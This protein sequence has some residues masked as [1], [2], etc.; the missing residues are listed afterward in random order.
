MRIDYSAKVGKF[1]VSGMSTELEDLRAIPNRKY[2]KTSG[3][4]IAGL[5]R[6]NVNYLRRW[7]HKATKEAVVMMKQV[8]Q[9][10]VIRKGALPVSFRFRTDPKPHQLEPLLRMMVSPSYALTMDPGTGKTKVAIDAAVCRFLERKINAELVV[11]PNSIKSNWEDEIGIHGAGEHEVFIYDPSMK[12]R[13]DKWC[14]TSFPGKL[15]WL[16][17]GV[18]SFSQGSAWKVAEQFLVMHHAGFDLDESSRIKTHDSTRTE[19]LI[20]L[21]RFAKFQTTMTGTPIS[22][23]LHQFWPQYEFLDPNILDMGFYAFRNHFSVM[24]GY[25]GKQIIGS[26][27]QEEFIDLVAPNTFRASKAECLKDLPPKIYQERKVEPSAEQKRIY[28]ELLSEGLSIVG[29]KHISY[30]NT[31]VRDL[32]LQQIAGGFVALKKEIIP[33][34]PDEDLEAYFERIADQPAEPI[35]GPN[36]KI[37]ELMAL[38]DEAPGKVIIWSRF[39]P[40]IYA[41]CAA[42]RK[43][44]GDESVV[45]FHGDVN[46][47]G[48]TLARRRFQND[49]TC[50]FFVGQI[51]TGGIGITLTAA[52]MVIYFSNAW[53]LEDRTQSEDRAHR[54]DPLNQDRDSILY[55][56]LTTASPRPWVDSKILQALK[57][58][59]DYTDVVLREIEL[60]VT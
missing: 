35:P 47:D 29:D 15:K 51:S 10:P 25:K 37:Q 34:G 49:S 32:R 31:L 54:I 43:E 18:E 1:V 48:R 9:G 39:K 58:G 41:I 28:N 16:I 22:K 38:V 53:A 5:T 23:G 11:C 24:G 42:L 13:F 45:E 12:K 8:E 4:W 26:I 30:D 2:D 21:G 52:T 44:Y 55:V 46:E 57:D 59:K 36:P 6:A 20:R 17:M 33:P 7:E 27:N 56:D 3:F 60:A 50:R 40:E 19:I 14:K